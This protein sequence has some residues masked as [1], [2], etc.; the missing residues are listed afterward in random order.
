M[1]TG[2]KLETGNFKNKKVR[3]VTKALCRIMKAA[4]ENDRNDETAQKAMSIL[5]QVFGMDNATIANC[6]ILMDRKKK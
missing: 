4:S 5:G 2:I 1:A 3:Q 6:T